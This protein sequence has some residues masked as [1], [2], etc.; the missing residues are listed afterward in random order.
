MKKIVSLLRTGTENINIVVPRM[1]RDYLK[2]EKGQKVEVE[3]KGETL[4]I[5]KVKKE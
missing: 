4:I 2:L 3:L 1:F 5:R